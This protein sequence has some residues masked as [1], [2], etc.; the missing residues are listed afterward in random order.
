MI[1]SKA[2]TEQEKKANTRKDLEKLFGM[3]IEGETVLVKSRT[4]LYGLSWYSVRIV[5]HGWKHEIGSFPYIYGLYKI[6]LDFKDSNSALIVAIFS[7]D[8]EK[9]PKN[10][11][12]NARVSSKVLKLMNFDDPNGR[13][14]IDLFVHHNLY[15]H[16]KGIVSKGF[17]FTP[18]GSSKSKNIENKKSKIQEIEGD[19]EYEYIESGEE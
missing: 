19:D 13:T 15:Y 12:S 10:I 11:I 1:K 4:K 7:L 5:S 14:F 3:S 17:E 16:M 18:Y 2:L 8:D 6:I 9:K